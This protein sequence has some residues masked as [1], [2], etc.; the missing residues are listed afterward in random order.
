MRLFEKFEYIQSR[1]AWVLT[2]MALRFEVHRC[3]AVRSRGNAVCSQK[4][5]SS[6]KDVRTADDGDK[7][8]MTPGRRLY[9]HSFLLLKTFLLTFSDAEIQ[10]CGNTLADS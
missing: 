3:V 6:W 7:S 1:V 8:R 2:G 5:A 4:H 9:M 10:S